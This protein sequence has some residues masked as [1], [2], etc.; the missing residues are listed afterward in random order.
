M[1]YFIQ[2]WMIFILAMEIRDQCA[3]Y[4]I[5][6]ERTWYLS[7][8]AKLLDENAM[9]DSSSF[10]SIFLARILFFISCSVRWRGSRTLDS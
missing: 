9:T 6:H 2:P 5:S 10:D 8:F 7:N 3:L 1:I 4:F